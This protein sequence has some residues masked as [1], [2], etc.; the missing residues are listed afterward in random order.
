MHWGQ[1][2]GGQRRHWWRRNC[3]SEWR[4]NWNRWSCSIHCVEGGGPPRR[5]I[6]SLRS[7][8]A[9]GEWR[10]VQLLL[11]HHPEPHPF[12]RRVSFLAEGVLGWASRRRPPRW[13]WLLY[14]GMTSPLHTAPATW[15]NNPRLGLMTS[16]LLCPSFSDSHYLHCLHSFC[17]RLPS[18]LLR[19]G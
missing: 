7:Y 13:E 9:E 19:V 17:I 12:G 6:N 4:S 5:G 15:S 18:Q 10:I 8:I 14:W 2:P 16:G 11:S 3:V 1:G